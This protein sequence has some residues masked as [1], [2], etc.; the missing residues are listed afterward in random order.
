MQRSLRLAG[1]LVLVAACE[2]TT[3]PVVSLGELSG[4]WDVA[5]WERAAAANPA[6]KANIL[7]DE[8]SVV[9]RIAP[10]GEFLLTVSTPVHATFAE[11]GTISLRGDTLVYDGQ[12]DEAAFRLRFF[13]HRMTWLALETKGYD[14]NDDG[15]PEATIDNVALTRR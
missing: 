10:N 6:L 3:A 11:T 15:V 14:V 5:S 8:M 9:L 13:E 12:N 4:T 1:V 7:A 2:S